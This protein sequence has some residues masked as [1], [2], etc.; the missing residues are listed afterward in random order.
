MDI[1]INTLG[2]IIA[3]ED[4]GQYLKII[5]DSENT[6]GFI[7]LTSTNTEFSSCFDSWVANQSDLE[8]FI[9]ESGWKIQWMMDSK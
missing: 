5:D 1:R 4:L 6:G 9:N 3:G 2:R 8:T 7:I